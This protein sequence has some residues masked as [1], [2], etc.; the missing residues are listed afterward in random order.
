[1]L[2]LPTDLFPDHRPFFHDL[3][4]CAALL[5]G[6]S[7]GRVGSI[8]FHSTAFS[9]AHV[10]H[11]DRNILFHTVSSSS[12]IQLETLCDAESPNTSL[13]VSLSLSKTT[14]RRCTAERI[15]SILRDRKFDAKLFEKQINPLYLCINIAKGYQ[16]QR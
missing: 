1:M 11:D 15:F 16:I 8:S 9:A 6:I 2:A 3:S 10:P 4:F 7:F 12:L 5:S 14:I 13:A